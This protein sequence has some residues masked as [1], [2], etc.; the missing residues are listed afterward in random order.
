[1]SKDRSDDREQAR[2]SSMSG[3]VGVD[4][5]SIIARA[6]ASDP[7]TRCPAVHVPDVRA[8]D[9]AELE[10]LIAF[11]G[12]HRGGEPTPL[13]A[14]E[15]ESESESGRVFPRGTLLSDGRLDL[16]KQA[17]G[18]DGARS[19]L[20]AVAGHGWIHSVLLGTNAIGN[21]GATAV[22]D[23]IRAGATA[24]SSASDDRP[25]D[26]TVYLGC[27]RIDERG[28]RALAD[29]L[30][31]DQSVSAL[32]L[33]RNPIGPEGAQAIAD[34]LAD[35]RALRT[36]D[37]FN[38]G[39]G[40]RGA[41]VVV[42]ALAEH[43]RCVEHLYLG[44]NGVGVETA[45]ALVECLRRNPVLTSLYVSINRLGDHGAAILA[46]GLRDNRSL[47]TLSLS[48]N[49]IGPE[50]AAALVAA[51][52]DHATLRTL[53]LGKAAA[54]RAL[55][56]KPNR[57]GNDGA[58]HIA[59]LVTRNRALRALDLRHNGITSRGAHPIMQAL[60][61][62]HTLVDLRLARYVARSIRR[63]IRAHLQ[64]NAGGDSMAR[65]VPAHVARIRS[66]YRTLPPEMQD[67]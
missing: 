38:T 41:A 35:N 64:R 36:L 15:S 52:A 23:Y 45:R 25:D 66:V 21:D 44:G 3:A 11:L 17:I 37:L 8:C 56:E 67:G 26:R 14:A 39:I 57:L 2:D 22:A 65:P 5:D 46:E 18:P 32:W 61:H 33:K 47:E 62:N 16:C 10:P 13:V 30:I 28:T 29:A 50:G 24:A 40:D 49:D 60:E 12:T 1:M 31:A 27:N 54:T 20:E 4:R 58:H 6:Q 59:D 63:R 34:M 53:D 51:L 55:D 48:S 42:R 19:I 7:V 9:P 43:N